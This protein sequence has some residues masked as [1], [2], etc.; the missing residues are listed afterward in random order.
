MQ[1]RRPGSQ[2]DRKL[3]PR[4]LAAMAEAAR[5]SREAGAGP[6]LHRIGPGVPDSHRTTDEQ[7]TAPARPQ[8][9]RAPQ[10]A[11]TTSP[12]DLAPTAPQRLDTPAPED[13]PR[14]RADAPAE[15]N[16][17]SHGPEATA[18]VPAIEAIRGVESA[19]SAGRAGSTESPAA[20]R[21]GAR[22][23]GSGERRLRWA[24]AAAATVLV[25]LV[26]ALVATANGGGRLPESQPI[27]TTGSPGAGSSRPPTGTTATSSGAGAVPPTSPSTSTPPPTS[28]P[29]P[30]STSTS[31]APSPGPTLAEPAGPPALSAL[32][33]ASGRAGQTVTVTGSD[34]LSSSGRISA[35]VGGQTAPVACP[36]QTACTVVIP[37]NPGPAWSAPV[38]I[39]TDSGTSNPLVFNYR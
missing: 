26:A 38:T 1:P 9:P 2:R 39:T 29:T 11:M 34:F 30:T 32:A 27:A 17:N 33:P 4:A 28:N 20:I 14:V 18:T 31:T 24:I 25:V 13:A 37:P 8:A 10:A 12:T 3:S 22:P 19:P 7:A 36:D 23:T 16:R 5:R 35:Q 6:E 21:P 15:P